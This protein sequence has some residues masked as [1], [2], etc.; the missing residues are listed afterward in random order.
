MDKNRLNEII[1]AVR[2]AAKLAQ[3]RLSKWAAR[4][5]YLGS[6]KKFHE[7]P[8]ETQQALR[9]KAVHLSRLPEVSPEEQDFLIRNA[10]NVAKWTRPKGHVDGW[11]DTDPMQASRKP[12]VREI[13]VG[14]RSL[15]CL[16]SSAESESE[17]LSI[18]A[19]E[20]EDQAELTDM[21]T[22]SYVDSRGYRDWVRNRIKNIPKKYRLAAY[23][24][25]MK[26]HPHRCMI[27][28]PKTGEYRPIRNG[29][30]ITI[31]HGS[32]EDLDALYLEEPADERSEHD[33]LIRELDR[34]Q[35][36]ANNW[37]ESE[38]LKSYDTLRCQDLPDDL[39]PV[40][41]DFIV[42]RMA[43][44]IACA[45]IE[46]NPDLEDQLL[47]ITD[48]AEENLRKFYDD[49]QWQD[50]RMIKGHTITR[51]DF[52]DLLDR[53]LRE[54]DAVRNRK[55]ERETVLRTRFTVRKEPPA[56]V[57]WSAIRASEYKALEVAR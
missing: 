6:D 32:N 42:R 41:D 43:Q 48:K 38:L 45:Y 2:K 26:R 20:Q 57:D 18:S 14:A 52:Y 5:E 31:V 3:P 54:L 56:P 11:L 49:V 1:A 39:R 13:W 47:Q 30:V 21:Q 10:P 19:L 51:S 22:L 17:G 53:N 35:I 28:D 7:L 23:N 55:I 25:L 4:L 15:N 9:S 16:P 34:D 36:R 24:A 37:T 50:G 40:P 12:V 44:E 27:T 29:D 8:E 33:A 46:K